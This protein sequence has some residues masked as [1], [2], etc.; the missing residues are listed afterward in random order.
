MSELPRASLEAKGRAHFRMLKVTSEVGG[1]AGVGFSC[2]N[3]RYRP[4]PVFHLFQDKVGIASLN[5]STLPRV[6]RLQNPGLQPRDAAVDLCLLNASFLH[7][8]GGKRWLQSDFTFAGDWKIRP[9]PRVRRRPSQDAFIEVGSQQLYH[10]IGERIAPLRI[11]MKKSASR[12]E[13]VC[14]RERAS[15]AATIE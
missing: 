5:T 12:V 3:F 2:L 1:G 15:W 8:H 11:R 7:D 14:C 9:L 10:I 13:A 6:Y 4:Q